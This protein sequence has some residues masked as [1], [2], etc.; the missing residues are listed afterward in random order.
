LEAT[1]RIR[2]FK[3]S[4]VH[5]MLRLGRELEGGGADVVYMVQGEPDFP[6]PNPILR[7]INES[8]QAGNTHYTAVAGLNA[9]RD[10]V[11]KHA[12]RNYK[13]PI[14]G[15]EEVMITTGAT[16]GLFNAIMALVGIGDEVILL[17]PGYIS[18]YTKMVE[19]A[20]GSVRLVSCPLAGDSY[21]LDLDEISSAI[22]PK[23]KALV[24]NS[25]ANPTGKVFTPLELEALAE[26]V[27]RNHI[28]VISDE[29]YAF[30]VYDNAQHVSFGSISRELFE[31]CITIF[32]GSKMYAMTGWRI[33]YSLAKPEVVR[34]MTAVQSVTARCAAT[35][36]QHGL[37]AALRGD[38]DEEVHAMI[39]AYD[40]RRQAVA[41]AL[42]EFPEVTLPRIE[43]AFYAFPRFASHVQ[44]SF[45]FA[46]QLLK[47]EHIV[48]TPGAYYGQTGETHLRLSF[49]CEKTRILEGFHRIRRFWE[50][51]IQMD[52]H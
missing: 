50:R 19:M 8:G 40:E 20:G 5:E 38:A 13:Q 41:D 25:P 44:D 22:T 17:E 39:S 42:A 12:V 49:S 31:N 33:G 52:R 43:G 27:L 15:I 34:W 48:T 32:T 4:T 21:E 7:A 47:E 23:T 9:V 16:Q 46:D 45:A 35:P 30:L 51:Q 1:E 28:T 11:A 36:V 14:R 2:G 37:M 18:S 6:T 29:A 3:T 10:I 26:I 24:L